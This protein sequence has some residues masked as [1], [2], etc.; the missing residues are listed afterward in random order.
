MPPLEDTD[1]NDLREVHDGVVAWL[2][3]ELG[4]EEYR[5]AVR[6]TDQEILVSKFEPGFAAGLHDLL[7]R[8]PEL[9]DEATVVANYRKMATVLPADTPRVD[10]WHGAMHRALAQAGVRLEI[11]DMR[12][13]E[14]R[15]GIDSVRA[16]MDAVLWTGPAVSDGL[17]LLADDRDIFTRYYGDFADRPVRNHCP[18]SAFARRMLAHAWLACTD[19]PPPTE[20]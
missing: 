11:D 16:V 10:A 12:L 1:S 9:F 14:V 3:D 17:A 13:A 2:H 6:V 20:T 18:G 15:T 8:L 19:T 7:D 5:R 4:V